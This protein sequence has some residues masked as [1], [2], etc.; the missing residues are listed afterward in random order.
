MLRRISDSFAAAARTGHV[1]A[2][3]IDDVSADVQVSPAAAAERGAFSQM[4]DQSVE[5]QRRDL[6]HCKHEFGAGSVSEEQ[7]DFHDHRRGQNQ[8]RGAKESHQDRGG[9][10][11]RRKG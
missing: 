10:S 4:V 11:R 7:G 2:A 6:S 5:P 9:R 1:G 8:A 3:T